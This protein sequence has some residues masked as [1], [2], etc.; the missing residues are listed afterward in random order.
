MIVTGI[1]QVTPCLETTEVSIS[2][3]SKAIEESIHHYNSKLIGVSQTI[4]NMKR[5]KHG[6]WQEKKKYQK[7]VTAIHA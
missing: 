2:M 7:L 4:K 6:T 1:L 5:K 3:I